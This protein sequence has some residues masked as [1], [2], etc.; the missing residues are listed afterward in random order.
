MQANGLALLRVDVAVNIFCS[1]FHRTNIPQTFPANTF[2]SSHGFALN[3]GDPS[4]LPA[5]EAIVPCG[6][7]DSRRGVTMMEL[8]IQGSSHHQQQE[9]QGRD[10]YAEPAACMPVSE[11]LTS[12]QQGAGAAFSSTATASNEA[13]LTGEISDNRHM[14]G[15][16]ITVADT[17]KLITKDFIEHFHFHNPVFKHS[18]PV[19]SE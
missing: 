6:I 16:E 17:A 7:Q 13:R 10:T 1:K 12:C 18:E 9:E 8:E 15:N 14:E 5:F 2:C 4:L 19:A 11:S 3:V